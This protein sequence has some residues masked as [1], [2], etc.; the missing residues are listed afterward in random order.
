M[1]VIFELPTAMGM[2]K[3]VAQY[4]EDAT[5]SL[6]RYVPSRAEDLRRSGKGNLK[7][8]IHGIGCWANSYTQD[9]SNG[10][11]DAE[12]DDLNHDVNP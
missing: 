1:D 2:A 6:E 4:G 11:Q 12:S 7:E 10:E 8:M 9:H 5:D 3:K